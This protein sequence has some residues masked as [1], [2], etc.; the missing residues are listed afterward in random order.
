[1]EPFA[2]FQWF[3]GQLTPADWQAGLGPPVIVGVGHTRGFRHQA[4][5]TTF[6]PNIA[7]ASKKGE[8]WP[9]DFCSL[10]PVLL[11]PSPLL[12]LYDLDV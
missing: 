11:H 7:R 8:I 12:L 2:L 4:P 10:I 3:V 5:R 1:V 9:A 6:L